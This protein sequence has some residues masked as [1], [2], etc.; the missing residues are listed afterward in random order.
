MNYGAINIDP[1]TMGG[2]PVFVGTRVPIQALFDYIESGETLE[3]FLDNF[4]SVT[5]EKA[6]KVLE[7]D[8]EELNERLLFIEKINMGMAEATQGR[9]IPQEKL[10][11]HFRKKWSI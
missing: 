8:I 2:T 1:E 9:R 6:I 3:E 5:K 11:E 4:P 7:F 10:I